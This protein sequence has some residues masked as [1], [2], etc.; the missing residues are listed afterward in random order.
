MKIRAERIFRLRI[1]RPGF[2]L[3]VALAALV[4]VTV[5][6]LAFFSRAL[7]NRQVSFSSTNMAKADYLAKT[8]LDFLVSELRQEIRDG[9]TALDGGTAG[10]PVVYQPL[11]P[12][13][14][15]PAKIGVV[16][17]DALGQRTLAKV[18]SAGLPV[19]PLGTVTASPISISARS[20]NSRYLSVERWFGSGGPALGAQTNSL[21]VWFYVTRDNGVTTPSPAAGR[22]RGSADYVVGRFAFTVY[23]VSGLLD[24]NVAGHPSAAATNAGSKSSAAAADLTVLDASFTTN[25]VN[26]FVVWRNGTS[27]TASALAYETYLTNFAA[28]RGFRE[29]KLGHNVFL[30]RKDLLHAAEANLVPVQVLPYFSHAS[31]ARTVPSW[32]PDTNSSA[33]T[34]YAG[35]GGTT[36]V[37][38]RDEAN[39]PSSSNRFIPNVR[40]PFSRTITRYADDGTAQTYE[41]GAGEPL[42]QKRFSLAKLAWLTMEGPAAGISAQAIEA[43]FGLR[44]S[45]NSNPS[46][47]PSNARWQYIAGTSSPVAVKT[48]HEVAQE[49]REPNFFELLKA[50]ILKGSL[51]R[52]PGAAS[53]YSDL[54]DSDPAKTIEG[55][56]G[57]S[58]DKY[59]ADAD[60]HVLQIGAN[61][62]DQADADSF[63]TAVYFPAFSERT[64]PDNVIDQIFN[65]LYG[66][67]N[68]PYLHR[69]WVVRY[70]DPKTSD[71]NAINGQ[72]IKFWL[73]PELWNV[74]QA[75]VLASNRPTQF[76]LRAYGGVRAYWFHSSRGVAKT[77]SLFADVDQIDFDTDDPAH[78][79]LYFRDSGGIGSPFYAKPKALKTSDVDTAATASINLYDPA[80]DHTNFSSYVTGNALNAYAGIHVM[81]LPYY[82]DRNNAAQDPAGD[83]DGPGKQ[84]DRQPWYQYNLNSGVEGLPHYTLALEYWDGATWR[85]YTTFSRLHH[86]IGGNVVVDGTANPGHTTPSIAVK[87]GKFEGAIKLADRTLAH[88]PDPRT[89]R[90][91][92]T[93]MRENAPWGAETSSLANT[94]VSGL[95]SGTPVEDVFPRRTSGFR[96]SPDTTSKMTMGNREYVATWL[97][98]QS[99]NPTANSG[100]NAY[101]ADP[102][103]VVR[104]GDGVRWDLAT[105]DGVYPLHA[106]NGSQSAV[107]RRPVIL[108]RPFRSVGELG[109]AYRDLPG[110]N[111]DFWTASSGDA[112]LL[113]LFCLTDAPEISA[114]YLDPNAAPMPVLKAMLTGVTTMNAPTAAATYPTVTQSKL[115]AIDAQTVA[116]AIVDRTQDASLIPLTSGAGLVLQ[117]GIGGG[118]T[119]N[120]ALPAAAGNATTSGWVDRSNKAAAEAPVRALAG[121]TDVRTWNL[122]IDVVAQSGRLV[123]EADSLQNFLV[124]GERRYWL[125]IAIDRYTGQVLARQLEP[126]L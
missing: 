64:V 123:P 90:F 3:V 110:K 37:A 114:G 104:P 60:R 95:S 4:I 32:G 1:R 22:T 31:R 50:G 25:K 72:D 115:T 109:Y 16:A 40:H 36:E 113:D 56:A 34:N 100:N 51:G 42:V 87:A 54:P 41:V 48:L 35:G 74:H 120:N 77:T 28:S 39:A 76:R 93:Q 124:E 75:P 9:S 71:L 86:V 107:R 53:N 55:P 125:H 119:I 91:S 70:E 80:V 38:Y 85:P 99:S 106:S 108:D 117:L 20:A 12:T 65:T 8:A 111:L 82:R 102:D 19:R 52:D 27:D 29:A 101:Y 2:A 30:S 47:Q 18:S 15:R 11:S 83:G 57:M 118:D 14:M 7:L 96:Y 61:I 68:L 13:N 49:G 79:N 81:S 67:E 5:L 21:P 69:L 66:V 121:V 23:D 63:P 26:D 24:A 44:W 88:S 59:S 17:P 98:N 33:M 105:G 58:F 126:V 43:C 6:V 45:A 10:F 78:R 97:R 94:V 103:G 116:Q 73:Q 122:L 84:S 92:A 89:D 46:G 112:A 62:I